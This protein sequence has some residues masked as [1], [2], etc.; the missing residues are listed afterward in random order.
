MPATHIHQH[1]HMNAHVITTAECALAT[2]EH[3]E[4]VPHA[5]GLAMYAIES[6]Y[7]AALHRLQRCKSAILTDRTFDRLAIT[8]ANT[9]R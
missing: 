6:I 3:I 7:D 1:Q 2:I 9:I 5:Q 8:S 4:S